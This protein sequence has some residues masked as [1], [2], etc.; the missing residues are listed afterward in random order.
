MRVRGFPK[1]SI[2][3]DPRLPRGDGV[4]HGYRRSQCFNTVPVHFPSDSTVGA[5]TPAEYKVACMKCV[6]QHVDDAAW[7]GLMQWQRRFVYL[8]TIFR[9]EL[10][11]PH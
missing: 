8:D 2:K 4:E 5:F 9:M 10:L 6:C 7:T 3:P 1:R 11:P